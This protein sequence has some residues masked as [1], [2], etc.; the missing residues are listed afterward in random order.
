MNPSLHSTLSH[1]RTVSRHTQR[2]HEQHRVTWPQLNAA[3]IGAEVPFCP[4]PSTSS[5]LRFH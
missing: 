2:C 4:E 3:G 1:R 5:E